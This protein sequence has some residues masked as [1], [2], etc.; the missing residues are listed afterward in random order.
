MKTPTY[1]ETAKRM[2]AVARTHGPLGVAVPATD[3]R[4]Q[5]WT[6]PVVRLDE[7]TDD[8]RIAIGGRARTDPEYSPASVG[9]RRCPACDHWRD[10]SPAVKCSTCGVFT[11]APGAA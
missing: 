11:L 2:R 7:L 6:G 8:E 9:I 1:R 10:E 5:G 4:A 3:D